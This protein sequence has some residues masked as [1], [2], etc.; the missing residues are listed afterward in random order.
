MTTKKRQSPTSPTTVS[1]CSFVAEAGKPLSD[2]G[3]GVAGT[4]AA[5]LLQQ[6][7][8][9]SDVAAV[10]RGSAPGVME[11]AIKIGG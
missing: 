10:L 3:M 11:T 9:I 6:A 1:N 4:L 5:A 2:A 8:A 7:T